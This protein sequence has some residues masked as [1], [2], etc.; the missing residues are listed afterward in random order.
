MPVFD[1]ASTLAAARATP[2]MATWSA[3]GRG[4]R[5]TE[6]FPAATAAAVAPAPAT[7]AR[8]APRMTTLWLRRVGGSHHG[9]GDDASACPI[10]VRQHGRWPQRCGQGAGAPR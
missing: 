6:P 4:E 2:P 3:K 7:R 9:R 5:A 10:R 1:L 8:I